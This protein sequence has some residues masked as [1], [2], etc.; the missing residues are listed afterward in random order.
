MN[1]NDKGMFKDLNIGKIDDDMDINEDLI[2]KV[3]EE[4]GFTDIEFIRSK[5]KVCAILSSRIKFLEML[6]EKINIYKVTMH[7]YNKFNKKIKKIKSIGIL[8]DELISFISDDM[9]K[10]AED[11]NLL[12]TSFEKSKKIIEEYEQNNITIAKLNRLLHF[13]ESDTNIPFKSTHLNT[14]YNIP[15]LDEDDKNNIKY[16]ISQYDENI[17]KEKALHEKTREV[18]KVNNE[19]SISTTSTEIKNTVDQEPHVEV[20]LEEFSDFSIYDNE[21]DQIEKK[22]PNE[23]SKLIYDN[24]M[25]GNEFEYIKSLFPKFNDDSYFN[26]KNDLIDLVSD[27]LNEIYNIIEEDDNNHE[28]FIESQKYEKILNQIFDYFENQENGTTEQDHSQVHKI[29]IFYSNSPGGNCYVL[30]DLKQFDETSKESFVKL[31]NKLLYARFSTNPSQQKK[32]RNNNSLKGVFELKAYNVRLIYKHLGN[33]NYYVMQALR[34]SDHTER[35]IVENVVTRDR[36]CTN[37]F[38]FIQ[39]NLNNNE[40]ISNIILENDDITETLNNYGY[41]NKK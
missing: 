30:E 16:F 41:K 33:N 15:D 2:I 26:I 20:L 38:K 10:E 25:S 31:L 34:K 7:N 28:F 17:E 22:E 23:K 29:N 27:Y 32:L 37:Q 13:I 11:L 6:E 35:E 12:K 24:F 1:L 3:F 14:F 21:V 9:K 36:I 5:S 8:H 4:L 19:K 40:V 18:S 39:N